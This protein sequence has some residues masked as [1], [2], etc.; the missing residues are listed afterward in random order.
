MN[1]RDSIPGRDKRFSVLHTVQTGS[2]AHHAPYPMAT[3][4][5]FAEVKLPEHEADFHLMPWLRI[6]LFGVALN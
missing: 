3:A 5:T 6:R 1:D 2:G 4:K